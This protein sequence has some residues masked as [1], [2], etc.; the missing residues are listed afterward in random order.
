MKPQNP[1]ALRL[2]LALSAFAANLLLDPSAL[3]A[4]WATNGPMTMA[5]NYPTATLLPNGEVLVAGGFGGG[6]LSDT[7]LYDPPAGTWVLTGSMSNKRDGHT[8][9][10]LPNGKVLAAGGNN[11]TAAELYDPVTGTWAP[12]GAMTAIHGVYHT[13]TLLLNGKVL[14][15]GA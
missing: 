13:A 1:K 8:A 11:N 9:T 14:V 6:S 3:A 4:S 15:V 7:E 10:M 5:R 12:A 2:A